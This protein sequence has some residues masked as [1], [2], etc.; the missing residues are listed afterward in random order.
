VLAGKPERQAGA[1]RLSQRRPLDCWTLPHAR[2]AERSI[3]RPQWVSCGS[4]R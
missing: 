3:G 4:R 2:L 1:Y